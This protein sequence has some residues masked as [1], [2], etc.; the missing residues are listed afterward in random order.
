VLKI[1]GRDVESSADLTRQVG[2][3]QPGEAIRVQVRRNGAV[4]D[5]TIRSGTRPDENVL[6]AN[7]PRD[8]GSPSA[9]SLSGPLGLRVST[10]KSGG[11]Q[12]DAVAT[13]SDARVKGLKAGDVIMRAGDRATN[14]P[15][16]LKA[17]VDEAQKAGRKEVLVLVARNGQRTFLTLKIEPNAPVG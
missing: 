11:L 15:E 6:K 5:F 7:L 8:A 9:P 4:R 14:A 13:N 1:N 2:L 16:D 12:V 3:A 10:N 17:A